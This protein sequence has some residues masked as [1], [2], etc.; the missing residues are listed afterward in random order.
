MR[1]GD[2]KETMALL[3][4][5][6]CAGVQAQQK[7]TMR[8]YFE[9]L[10][11]KVAAGQP[12]PPFSQE[13]YMGT[14]TVPLAE[15]VDAAPAIRVAL[16]HDATVKYGAGMLVGLTIRP[17]TDAV[18]RDSREAMEGVIARGS[19]LSGLLCLPYLHLVQFDRIYVGAPVLEAYLQRPE[20][21]GQT[22]GGAC[23]AQ[24][25]LSISPIP[26]DADAAVAKFIRRGDLDSANLADMT[27]V[28]ANTHASSPQ[29]VKAT[30]ELIHNARVNQYFWQEMHRQPQAV[31]DG[32]RQELTRTLQEKETEES[33][34][35]AKRFLDQMDAANGNGK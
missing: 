16:A 28:V 24:V 12:L 6:V 19:A 10:N 2:L 15:I 1:I 33:R 18:L 4:L 9:D 34:A 21:A 32:V 13:L 5:V 7:Q 17:D 31:R 27:N 22:G 3:L 35:E 20:A 26:A 8:A 25:L 11:A 30:V 14:E 29:V 23:F